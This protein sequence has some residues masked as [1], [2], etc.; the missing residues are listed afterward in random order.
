MKLGWVT[1]RKTCSKVFFGLDAVSLLSCGKAYIPAMRVED[2]VLVA[3]V[4]VSVS[5]VCRKTVKL[6]AKN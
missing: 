3:S 1:L 2:I 5:V 4:C 6:L